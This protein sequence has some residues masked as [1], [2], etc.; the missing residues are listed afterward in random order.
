MNDLQ[1]VADEIQ[2]LISQ[3][4]AKDGNDSEKYDLIIQALGRACVL[5]KK[6]FVMFGSFTAEVMNACNL[7]ERDLEFRDYLDNA[8]R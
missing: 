3:A 4:Q 8:P 1:V 7:Q 6:L 5:S 2:N